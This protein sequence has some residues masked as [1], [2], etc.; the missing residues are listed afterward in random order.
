VRARLSPALL[1]LLLALLPAAAR[2]Q[3]RVTVPVDVGVGPA[4]YFITGPVFRDQPLHLGVKIS[5]QAVL[6]RQW[7]RRHQAVIPRGYRR[8]ALQ[9]EELRISPSL[10]IP[11][12]LILSP[13]VRNTGLYGVTWR[14]FGLS[15]PLASGTF[16]LSLDAGLLLTYAYLTS[17]TLADTH[18]LRPGLD[19]GARAEVKLSESLLV[20]VGWG[21]GLYIP[22]K[23]GS[24]GTGPL[25][26]SMFHLGQANLQLHVRFPYTTRL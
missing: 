21:S 19:L 10:L 8:Q 15:L 9:T 12:S 5:L 20:S 24:F 26:Q 11:D 4:A 2:A 6:D 25:D 7:L 14:P 3:R 22:Q 13:K 16:A 18:F 1:L 23:L 17:D